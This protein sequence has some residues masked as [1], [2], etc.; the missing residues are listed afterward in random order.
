[1]L[2]CLEVSSSPPRLCR[3]HPRVLQAPPHCQKRFASAAGAVRRLHWV[4]FKS[5]EI[6]II[7]IITIIIAIIN[8]ISFTNNIFI[9]I[10]KARTNEI[11]GQWL[12]G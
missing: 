1:M 3:L 9:I 11:N 2:S 10:I 7:T 5:A 6:I 12:G 8:A 4:T